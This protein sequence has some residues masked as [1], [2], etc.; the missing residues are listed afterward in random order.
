MKCKCN[1]EMQNFNKNKYYCSD[2]N[3]AWWSI[4]YGVYLHILETLEKYAPVKVR[5]TSGRKKL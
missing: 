4:P 1:K 5:K 3:L 2:C